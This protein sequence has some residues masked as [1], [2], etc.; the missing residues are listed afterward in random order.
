MPDSTM[1]ILAAAVLGIFIFRKGIT[2]IIKAGV[3]GVAAFI[4]II[5]VWQKSEDNIPADGTIVEGMFAWLHALGM[6][7]ADT[8]VPMIDSLIESFLGL[9]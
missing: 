4:A 2:N 5:F 6:R 3:Y 7:L 1:L 8:F 9:F